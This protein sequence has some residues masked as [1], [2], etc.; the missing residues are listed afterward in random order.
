MVSSQE[1]LDWQL[2]YFSLHPEQAGESLGRIF[3]EDPFQFLAMSYERLRRAKDGGTE[4]IV[5][6][7]FLLKRG[8]F[9][10]FLS[11][12]SKLTVAESVMLANLA[13]RVDTDFDLTLARWLLEA[14]EASEQE[15]LLAILCQVQLRPEVVRTLSGLMKSSNPR[16]RSRVAYLLTGV[17][18]DGPWLD[19]ALR[20]GDARTRANAIEALSKS[21]RADAAGLLEAAAQDP[22]HRVRG[23][24]LLGLYRRGLV[25]SL[26]PTAELLASEDPLERRAGLWLVEMTGDPRWSCWIAT[27]IAKSEA[28]GRRR[29]LKAL[30]AMRQRRERVMSSPEVKLDL[31]PV[32]E[33]APGWRELR[34]GLAHP[35]RALDVVL[36]EDGELVHE[37]EVE[38]VEGASDFWFWVPE[39][40]DV[41]EAPGV[42]VMRYAPRPRA[43]GPVKKARKAAEFRMLGVAIAD[44]VAEEIVEE[45]VL[46]ELP[47]LAQ[48]LEQDLTDDPPPFTCF[49]VVWL[50]GDLDE[51]LFH[52]FIEEARTRKWP[53]HVVGPD[54]KTF[55]KLVESTGGELHVAKNPEVAKDHLARLRRLMTASYLIRYQSVN[56]GAETLR[57]KL[58]S[59]TGHGEGEAKLR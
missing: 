26:A 56:P 6:V 5:L 14:K 48:R 16:I 8:Q 36:E 42:R 1:N 33:M 25:S 28:E 59:D 31:G 46:E 47:G 53:F 30:A 37:Y 57:V 39:N 17:D 51:K 44:E 24:A 23:N 20:D 49:V 38:T 54:V 58:M 32:K 27:M 35:V 52:A 55:R 2:R 11:G 29:C 34:L 19:Q 43:G 40:L 50:G 13:L 9:Q 15:R 18:P 7:S 45:E 41:A 21:K 4:A 10:W 22:H 3:D 12:S